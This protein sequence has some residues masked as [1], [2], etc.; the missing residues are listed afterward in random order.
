MK[1]R[2]I[3]EASWAS[4]SKADEYAWR[5]E[6]DP[7]NRKETWALIDSKGKIIRPN[8]S[9]AAAEALTMR[10]DLIKKY[11]KL[12]AFRTSRGL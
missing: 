6:A 1:L 3:L 4:S 2:D 8:L 11:G 12:R 9:Q 7:V 5:R 10:P